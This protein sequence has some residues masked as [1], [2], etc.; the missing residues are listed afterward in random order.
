MIPHFQSEK[1]VWVWSDR[2]E[3]EISVRVRFSMAEDNG[4]RLY[5]IHA[6]DEWVL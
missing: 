4:H 5:S 1:I 3:R 6:R 2:R